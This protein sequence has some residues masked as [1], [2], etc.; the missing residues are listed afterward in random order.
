MVS[1]LNKGVLLRSLATALFAIATLALAACGDVYVH[2]EFN[3]LAM[4]KSDAEVQESLGKP[5]S[6]DATNPQHVLWTY[7]SKTFDVENQNKRDIKAVVV[8]EPDPATKKLK[9]VKVE[10]QKS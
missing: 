1:S 3:K 7:Y 6:V 10:Y 5:T 9:V 2:E 4:N 8:F